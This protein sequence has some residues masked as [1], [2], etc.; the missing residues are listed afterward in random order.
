M[1]TSH[2]TRREVLR[3]GGL[4]FTGLMWSD[5]LRARATAADQPNSGRRSVAG[6]FGNAKACIVI[7]NYGG[8]SHLDVWDLKPDAPAEISGEFKPAATAVPGIAITEHLPRL[9]KLAHLYT[10]IRSVNHRDNDHAIGTYLALTGYSHPKHDILGIEPPASP[11]DLSSIGA[12]LSK[13]RL[14]GGSVFFC[15]FLGALLHFSNNDSMGRY[16]GCLGRS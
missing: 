8:P 12:V 10:I 14:S 7:F 4:A 9:A 3:I 2:K 15:I 5:W 1:Q 6:T 16:A 13:L 11:Q